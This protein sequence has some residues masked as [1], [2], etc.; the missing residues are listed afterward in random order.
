MPDKA[1]Y[2]EVKGKYFLVIDDGST[3]TLNSKK[4]LEKYLKQNNLKEV[5]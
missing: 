1:S 3:V 4:E 2:L 5:K